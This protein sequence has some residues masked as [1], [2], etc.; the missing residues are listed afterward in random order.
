MRRH[1]PWLTAVLICT[2][3]SCGD[4]PNGP[5]QS[6]LLLAEG[7]YSVSLTG[8]DL[9]A[10]PRIQVCSPTGVPPGGKNMQTTVDLRQENS[11]SVARSTPGAG[12]L[13]IRLTPAGPTGGP[14]IRVRGSVTGTALWSD[15]RFPGV[16]LVVRFDGVG[17]GSGELTRFVSFVTGQITGTIV[18]SNS[19]GAASTCPMV[20]WTMQLA[21]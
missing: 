15:D 9:S 7:R 10:D 6:G 3:W 1:G 19:A 4:P 5:G 8:F 2:S 14:T 18:F 13:V 20:Q 17:V 21:R 11:E 16:D 12:D